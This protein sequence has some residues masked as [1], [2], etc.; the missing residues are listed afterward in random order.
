MVAKDMNNDFI[1][2]VKTRDYE[3]LNKSITAGRTP[4]I[5]GNDGKSALLVATEEHNPSMVQWLLE[6]GANVDFYDPD[7]KIID[8]TCDESFSF[9]IIFNFYE[10]RWMNFA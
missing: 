10:H 6:H 3:Y 9:S 4:N 2:A 7:Y 8:Q 1:N 5:I